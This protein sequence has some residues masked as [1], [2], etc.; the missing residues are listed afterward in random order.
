MGPRRSLL[1]L[2]RSEEEPGSPARAERRG[3]GCSG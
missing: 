2:E 1:Q 3:I